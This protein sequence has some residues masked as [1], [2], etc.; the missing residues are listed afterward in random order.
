M[1]STQFSDFTHGICKC[2][3]TA[4]SS[5]VDLWSEMASGV[6][7][8]AVGVFVLVGLAVYV[9]LV[10]WEVGPAITSVDAQRFARNR[11]KNSSIF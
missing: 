11:K 9:Y 2:S 8:P 4:E 6:A 3:L 10:L 1:H 5:K 7:V